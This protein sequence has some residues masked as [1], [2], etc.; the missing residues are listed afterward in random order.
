MA[1]CIYSPGKVRERARH[2]TALDILAAEPAQKSLQIA[3]GRDQVGGASEVPCAS[4]L[5]AFLSHP[6][7]HTRTRL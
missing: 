7:T 2:F 4:F 1:V 3:E 5:L 6:E